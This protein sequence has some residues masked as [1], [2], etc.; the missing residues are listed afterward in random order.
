MTPAKNLRFLDFPLW[1]VLIK[2]GQAWLYFC[3]GQSFFFA[4]WGR[5]GTLSPMTP[6]KNL[7]FLDFP[8]WGVLIKRGKHGYISAEAKFFL[9]RMGTIGDAVLYN[10]CQEPEVLGFPSLGSPYIPNNG[11]VKPKPSISRNKYLS[12]IRIWSFAPSPHQRAFRSPFG[13]LRAKIL[14]FFSK[15]QLDELDSPV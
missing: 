1:G 6:A 12:M 11:A 3:R 9:R 13:N 2:T 8:L 15:Y 7:R 10:P 4:G 5:L 14:S